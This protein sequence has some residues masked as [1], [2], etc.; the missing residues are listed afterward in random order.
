MKTLNSNSGSGGLYVL[1]SL[2]PQVTGGMEIFNYYFLNH[3]LN[4]S[5]DRIYYLGEHATDNPKGVFV[6]L[7]KRWPARL[8]Y[9][10][11]FFSTVRKLRR[12]LDYA[13]ISYAEESWVI[14]FAYAL[15]LRFFKIPYA[16][17]IHWGKEPDWRFRYPFH[18]YF[19]HA[20][21][22]I[23]VSQLICTAFKKEMPDQHFQYIPPLVPFVLAPKTRDMAKNDLGYSPQ[24][25][26][27]LFVGSLK[28]MKNPDQIVEAMRLIGPEFLD[29]HQI[30]LILAGKGELENE[31]RERVERYQL[32]KYIR[33]AGL[34][35]RE[36]IPDYYRAAD[37]YII[38]SDYEGTSVSLLEAMFNKMAI[39]A[40]DAPGINGMITHE[41]NGLLYETRDAEKLADAIR[42]IFS[43]EAWAQ[44][45]A[46][47]AYA[48]FEKRY[49]YE[50]MMEKYRSVFSSIS[51]NP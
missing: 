45:L 14:C 34:V 1:G 22:V 12:K 9:P 13:Y 47:N 29:L 37:A 48:D 38:S 30:R 32:G 46:E 17:T 28:G 10:F 27:L 50:S 51:T 25:K 5:A 3:Q 21:A 18:Y 16:I 40:S 39:I 6:Y 43:N 19:R 7:K 15:T 23:G 8:F 44:R 49:S 11:Q 4:G 42:R 26:I 35:S 20:R 36:M 2:Y 33:L 41:Q 31:I 24:E